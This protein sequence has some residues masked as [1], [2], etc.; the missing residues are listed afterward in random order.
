MGVLASDIKLI[1]EEDAIHNELAWARRLPDA[2]KWL[3][4]L[5]DK[6]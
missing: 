4:D 5:K 1:I 2:L 6:A 3:L